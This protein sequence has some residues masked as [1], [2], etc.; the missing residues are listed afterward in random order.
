MEDGGTGSRRLPRTVSRRLAS[1][2]YRDRPATQ[3]LDRGHARTTTPAA[4][5]AATAATTPGSAHRH[6]IRRARPNVAPAPVTGLDVGRTHQCHLGL[7]ILGCATNAREPRFGRDSVCTTCNPKR[8]HAT[9]S[10]TEGARRKRFPRGQIYLPSH[11]GDER[12][13]TLDELVRQDPLPAVEPVPAN[14]KDILTPEPRVQYIESDTAPDVWATHKEVG[15]GSNGR[16]WEVRLDSRGR[17]LNGLPG[18]EQTILKQDVTERRD[19]AR[20]GASYRP[21]WMRTEF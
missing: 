18:L 19:G 16:I 8:R 20:F 5:R 3:D 17:L 11:L 2:R 7:A 21:P 1:D 4:G 15:R 14:V 9:M 10:K 12:V 6:L 13:L